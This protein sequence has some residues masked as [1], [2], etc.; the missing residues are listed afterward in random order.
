[1]PLY[2]WWGHFLVCASCTKAWI[3]LLGYRGVE[4]SCHP[5]CTFKILLK[6]SKSFSKDHLSIGCQISCLPA[7]PLPLSSSCSFIFAG[8]LSEQWYLSIVVISSPFSGEVH[9]LGSLCYLVSSPNGTW[10][11]YTHRGLVTSPEAQ[12]IWAAL[13]PS[14]RGHHFV[15]PSEKYLSMLLQGSV[16]GLPASLLTP[17]FEETLVG[18]S[19]FRWLLPPPTVTTIIIGNHLSLWYV[20]GSVWVTGLT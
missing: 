12:D 18:F 4:L 7:L 20:S 10:R 5:V 9:L 14:R 17:G 16:S 3:V 2:Q 11:A 8:M 6:I 19:Y 15:F 13:I 1:M